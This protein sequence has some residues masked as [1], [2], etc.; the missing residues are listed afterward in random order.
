M[1]FSWRCREDRS[2]ELLANSILALLLTAVVFALF[3]AMGPGTAIP[4][5]AKLYLVD[6]TGLH[7]GTSSSFDVTKLD[8]I[9]AFP[10]FH[11]ALAVLLTHAHRGGV[12]FCPV[13]AL[14]AV[15]LVSVPSEGGH[16]LSDVLAGAAIAVMAIAATSSNNSRGTARPHRRGAAGAGLGAR[17]GQTSP[18][19]L[20]LGVSS[21]DGDP[22]SAAGSRQPHRR[23]RGHRAA[24]GGGQG[25]GRER[26]RRRRHA[27]STSACSEGGQ[28]ADRGRRQRRR[29]E[30]R[31]SSLWRSSGTAPRNCP[32]TI[33]LRIAALGFRGEAL[34]SIGAVSRLRIVSRP[35]GAESA[36]EIAVEA[37]GESRRRCRRRIHPAR[38]SRC[39]ICSSRPRRGS[40]S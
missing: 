24:G 39:A 17:R 34:P 36:W 37:G 28:S 9:V 4:E 13:A 26:D 16:Y 7:D 6:L 23:R 40:N 21:E 19:E 31:T 30:P 15:M 27:A 10:S 38:G 1:Y 22:P 35:P 29:H 32:M 25:T 33:C 2:C 18:V 20:Q 12:L 11:T 8:G 5:L 3:P 14:N